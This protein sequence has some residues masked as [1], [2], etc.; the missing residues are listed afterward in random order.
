L[1]SA[2]AALSALGD[3]FGGKQGINRPFQDFVYR[4]YATVTSNGAPAP[5]QA[6]N[7]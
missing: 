1:Q 5:Y 3:A 7:N 6:P 2:K 4:T